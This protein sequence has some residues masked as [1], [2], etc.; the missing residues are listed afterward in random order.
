MILNN[1]TTNLNNN[2]NEHKEL[3]CSLAQAAEGGSGGQVQEAAA[4]PV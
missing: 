1:Q 2:K 3:E 4:R